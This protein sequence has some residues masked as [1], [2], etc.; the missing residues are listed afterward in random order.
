MLDTYKP[1]G[2][3]PTAFL[4]YVDGE[5]RD[6]QSQS[7]SKAFGIK[8]KTVGNKK[9][10]YQEQSALPTIKRGSLQNLL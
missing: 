3:D 7:R 5:Q 1:H 9:G 10:R 8:P 6:D 4:P 2:Q